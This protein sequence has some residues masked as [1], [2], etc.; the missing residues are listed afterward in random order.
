MSELT[1]P[2]TSHTEPCA[3]AIELLLF[4]TS[5]AT[6]RTAVAGG[7][8]GIVVDCEVRGKARRQAGYDTEINAN[9]P[10]DLRRVRAATPATLVCRINAVGPWTP[11]E[12]DR[13][14]AEG[15]DEL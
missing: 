11:T 15:P 12:I 14:V 13:L 6:I 5:P 8:G 2:T 1:I 7:V 10:A 4:S 3:A 9:T